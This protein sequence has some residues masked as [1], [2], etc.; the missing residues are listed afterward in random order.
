M[1]PAAIEEATLEAEEEAP[2]AVEEAAPTPEPTPE[3]TPT[4]Y[5]WPDWYI[6][7][8]D[9]QAAIDDWVKTCRKTKGHYKKHDYGDVSCYTQNDYPVI[10]DVKKD[11]NGWK[12]NREYVGNAIYYVEMDDGYQVVQRFYFAEGRLFRVID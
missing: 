11:V 4:P 5:V 8:Y 7:C 9:E 3:P 1:A 6:D 12:Y 10:I 2:Y